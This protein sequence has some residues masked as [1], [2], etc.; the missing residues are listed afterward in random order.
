MLIVT[1]LTTLNAF[2]YDIQIDNIYYYVNIND[3]TCEVTY[4]DAN[5]NSYSG[6]II[7]PET[8]TYKT[9]KLRVTGIGYRAFYNC[10]DLASV[11]IGKS[12]SIIKEAAFMDCSGLESITIPN[13][14]TR[15]DNYA[16]SGCSSIKELILEDGTSSLSLGYSPYSYTFEGWTT[17]QSCGLFYP[18]PIEN[19]YI[20]RDISYERPP[21]YD[22]LTGGNPS[23]KSVTFGNCVTKIC[24]NTFYK[25]SNLT[26][27]TIGNSVSKIEDDAFEGCPNLVSIYL[28]GTIPPIVGNDNFTKS[29]YMDATVYVPFGSLATY[30]VAETWNN[31]WDIQEY[32]L[33]K[34]FYVNYIVDGETYATDSVKHGDTI[35]L[36]EIPIKEG[37]TFSGWSEVP[38]KMPANDI[39]VEGTFSV[40][41][42]T[43]TFMIDNEVYKTFN[44]K[45]GAEIELPSVPEKDGY[46]FSGWGNVPET[47][48]AKD[49]IIQGSYIADTAIEDIF[50]DLENIEVY[51]LK[52]V[53]ITETDKLT[54]GIYII[55][56]NKTFV[57]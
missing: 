52:G 17:N 47:M 50:I 21:F 26:S 10:T 15:I 28:E 41:S 9:K 25:C 20:G 13:S 56:G 5:Y 35:I 36:K 53:R 54:R 24:Y 44:V 14:V 23:I 11:T 7:I 29:H 8:V 45:Y 18:C 22:T 30:Q 34:Y 16:F 4:K 31:F 40:N 19:V 48:P 3:F 39:T 46:T 6:D 2:A 27:I 55:N 32:Y 38:E 33:D 12:V 42:Y 37:H 57:K 49:I 43:V 1:L 51:N